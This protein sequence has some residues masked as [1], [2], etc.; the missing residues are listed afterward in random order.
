[1]GHE[2]KPCRKRLGQS[3]RFHQQNAKRWTAPWRIKIERQCNKLDVFFFSDFPQKLS[4]HLKF[5]Q[6]TPIKGVPFGWLQGRRLQPVSQ[7][8]TGVGL[9]RQNVRSN[10]GTTKHQCS[11]LWH[12]CKYR[13]SIT[14]NQQ[15]RN[16][17]KSIKK[18]TVSIV[19]NRFQF[20]LYLLK[21]VEILSWI[22]RG[23]L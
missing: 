16:V 17:S 22:S 11:I 20:L 8:Q 2:A 21:T 10:L 5:Y 14:N 4:L 7:S 9:F 6:F 12:Q 19:Y 13:Q 23:C 18:S 3:A 15:F 1:M